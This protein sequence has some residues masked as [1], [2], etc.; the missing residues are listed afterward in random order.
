MGPEILVPIVAII[1]GYRLIARQIE[2]KRVATEARLGEGRNAD[3]AEVR[4]ELAQIRE[5]LADVLLE[6]HARGARSLPE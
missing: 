4:E 1:L 2:N 3:M 6:D 5:M